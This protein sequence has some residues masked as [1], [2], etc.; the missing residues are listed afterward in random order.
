MNLLSLITEQRPLVSKTIPVELTNGNDGRGN[1][2][3]KSSN[4]RKRLEATLRSLRLV[5][6]PFGHPVRIE[7]TRILG[8]SQRLWDADSVGRGNAKELVDALV[9]C[10]WFHDD[11]PKY[12]TACDYR[13]DASQRGNGP[14]VRI[15]V[16]ASTT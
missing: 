12:I 6:Q 14:A 7:V 11:G 5:R 16:F 4:V 13:Q 15:R 1:R 9:V 2:W 3:F 10:G 8:P